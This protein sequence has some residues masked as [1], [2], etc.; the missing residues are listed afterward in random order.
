MTEGSASEQ[1][2]LRNLQD[3]F[4][5]LLD[6]RNHYNDLSREARTA[7]DQLN[8]QRR[9]K[10]DGIDEF[11]QKRDALNEQMREHKELRNAYQDQAKALIAQRKGKV[12]ALTKSLP[13]QVRKLR[14]DVQG[15][16]ERQ[17]TTVLTPAKEREVVEQ[18]AEKR[19]E[20]TK[21]EK[22][23]G[24]QKALEVDLDDTDGAI[25]ALFKKADEEHEKVIAFQKEATEWH[26][27]F[28]AAVKEMR[29][30]A[31]EGDKKHQEFIAY[32][33]KAD[34]LHNKAMEL[35][36]KVMAVKGER[37]AEFEARRAE[38]EGYNQNARRSVN[39]PKAIEKAK[40]KALDELKKGGKIT[41]G[42]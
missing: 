22:E 15:L 40:D 4:H 14:N 13:L 25:D 3:K 33:T 32:K 26:D 31:G 38:L 17:E 42:F 1:V 34:E 10:A 8:A 6:Q 29:V 21:L 39:D 23:L 2:D 19:R 30:I 20:L 11:K 12:G 27:K 16:L 35:R 24:A 7:R 36:E 41:L 18:I 28:I 37:R 9:E 5:N